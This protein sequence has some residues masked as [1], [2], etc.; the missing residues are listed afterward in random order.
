M[1]VMRSPDNRRSSAGEDEFE[2]VR[3]TSHDL[4]YRIAIA[5]SSRN[6]SEVLA[7]RSCDATEPGGRRLDRASEALAI[8]GNKAERL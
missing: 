2:L 8:Y 1:S 7:V 4:E 5:P 6:G 3:T